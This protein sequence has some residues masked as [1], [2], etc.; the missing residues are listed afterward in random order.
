MNQEQRTVLV[1]DG[2]EDAR[3]RY[4]HYL[5][6]D[7]ETFYTIL[8]ADSGQAGLELWQQHQPDVVI[9]EYWLPDYKCSG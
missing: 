2:D 8:E 3:D 9:L 1:I 6:R 4:R 7:A 5:R